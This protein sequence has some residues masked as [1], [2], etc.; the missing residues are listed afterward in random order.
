M[1]KIMISCPT[2]GKAVPTGLTTE[3]IKF[4]SLAGITIPLQCPACMKL[5]K[6]EKKEAWVDKGE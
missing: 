4:E 3:T 5:H 2:V 6:W 1:P